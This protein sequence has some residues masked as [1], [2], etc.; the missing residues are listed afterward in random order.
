MYLVLFPIH[1]VLS[2]FIIIGAV[3]FD[4]DVVVVVV[5][6]FSTN[7]RAQVNSFYFQLI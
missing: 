2:I 6:V 4:D 3:V 1:V 5:V 7:L